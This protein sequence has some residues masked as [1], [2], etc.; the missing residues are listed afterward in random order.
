MVQNP[1]Y[2]KGP[3]Q[4]PA[5]PPQPYAAPP[6]PYAQSVPQPHPVA[7]PQAPVTA[8]P[9]PQRMNSEVEIFNGTI[10]PACCCCFPTPSSCAVKWEVTSRRVDY[11]RP[12]CCCCGTKASTAQ[13]RNI[14]DVDY[15]SCC[16]NGEV[17]VHM[18][19]P[20]ETLHIEGFGDKDALKAI[21]KGLT[22]AVADL[23]VNL[24]SGV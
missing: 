13:V 18:K 17:T 20:K 9:Q 8:P 6:Q 1:H 11:K 12:L 23:K 7:P 2:A 5:M 15:R 14:K 4:P 10:H 16:C 21:Y 19:D 3:A 24:L 22:K